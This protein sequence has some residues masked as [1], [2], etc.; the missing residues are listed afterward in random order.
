MRPLL[1]RCKLEA[2]SQIETSPQLQ[3][4]NRQSIAKRAES[5]EHARSLV[6]L[7]KDVVEAVGTRSMNT[8][9]VVISPVRNEEQ[10]LEKTIQSLCSQTILP[11]Q[12]LVVND[13]SSDRSAEI[14]ERWSE[15][16]PWLV[17]IHLP[18]GS[19]EKLKAPD[20]KLQ[21]GNRAFHA[22]EILAFMEGYQR[23]SVPS[24]DY[25]VKLDG[26]TGFAPDYF[27]RCFLEFE[28]D[29]RLGIG[30]GVICNLEGSTWTVEETPKFHVRGATKIYRRACWNAIGG[31][32][33][34]AGWDTIDEVKA[35][36]LGWNTSSFQHLRVL[37]YRFTGAANGMWRNASKD[38]LWNYVCG[39]HPLFLLAKCFK[40][41]FRK[42]Y[43]IGSL[44]MLHGFLMGYVR[45]IP[46]N[47]DRKLARYLRA[48]QLRRLVLLPS[49][50][51]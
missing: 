16:L 4:E 10:Y 18:D 31:V 42:P 48:Q 27:E 25:I 49:I 38:G 2:L 39:Y 46:R 13:G 34:G 32:I 41:L 20:S 9:Y 17:P 30:G 33:R 29:P 44:G 36:M 3:S 22:K 47:V 51:K 5:S 24:W 21:R 45:R 12:W 11:V 19:A 37:H 40:R 7:P 50:W 15:Q 14:I 6:S 8:R 26:D 28:K 23:V 1:Y 43:L 35:N